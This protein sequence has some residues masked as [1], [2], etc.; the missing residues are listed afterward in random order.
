MSNVVNTSRGPRFDLLG[1]TVEF[2]TSLDASQGFCVLRGIIPARLFVPLHSHADVED[3]YIVSGELEGI[4]RGT[5]GYERF[6][7]KAGDYIHVSGGEPHG[8]RNASASEPLVTLIITTPKLGQFF[9]E[10]GRPDI[11]K[12]QPVTPEDLTRF[13]RASEKYGYWN[14]T[15]EENEAVGLH[16]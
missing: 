3:F 16:F 7:G 1:P 9:A 12:P 10:V 15:P 5:G 13:M 6:S 11:G 2:L 14:A 8:W 4:R